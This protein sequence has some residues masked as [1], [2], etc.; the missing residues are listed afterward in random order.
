[1]CVLKVKLL[2]MNVIIIGDV[3]RVYKVV[4]ES[5]DLDLESS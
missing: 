3:V 2:S 5:R 1:M 4:N